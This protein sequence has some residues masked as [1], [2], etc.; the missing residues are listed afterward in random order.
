MHEPVPPQGDN[1]NEKEYERYDRRIRQDDMLASVERWCD[2]EFYV[3]SNSTKEEPKYICKHCGS[4]YL[5]IGNRRK[6]SEEE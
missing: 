2:H 6:S 5:K 1:M 3:K 4:I